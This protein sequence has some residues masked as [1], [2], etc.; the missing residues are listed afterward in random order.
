MSKVSFSWVSILDRRTHDWVLILPFLC[1]C[2]GVQ[3]TWRPSL[4]F[5]MW[6]FNIRLRTTMLRD[7]IA[8][9][10]SLYLVIHSQTP[11]TPVF[12]DWNELSS[13]WGKWKFCRIYWLWILT[14]QTSPYTVVYKT[15][16]HNP[17][18]LKIP[19]KAG[20]S[21]GYGVLMISRKMS[22]QLTTSPW[23]LS[24]QIT[25]LIKTVDRSAATNLLIP[26]RVFVSSNYRHKSGI[27]IH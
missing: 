24:H 10:I 9:C 20:S 16:L 1:F 12:T 17:T 5:L 3:K 14:V 21:P 15:F 26:Q 19:K 25:N 4:S 11:K 13:I 6:K 22:K 27:F 23:I 2:A 7:A 8:L 18:N